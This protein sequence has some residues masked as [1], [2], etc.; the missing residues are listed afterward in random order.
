M[1]MQMPHMDGCTAARAIRNSTDAAKNSIPIIA[2]TANAFSE[3][4][5]LALAAGMNCFVSKPINVEQL[6]EALASVVK[7]TGAA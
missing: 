2:L 7:T 4:R 5:D 6:L 1:D 3:D